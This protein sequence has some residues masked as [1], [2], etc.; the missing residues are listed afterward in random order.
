MITQD[1]NFTNASRSSKLSVSNFPRE[2]RITMDHTLQSLW[3][4]EIFPFEKISHYPS[5]RPLSLLN[6]E[7]LLRRLQHA[8]LVPHRDDTRHSPFF[9]LLASSFPSTLSYTPKA[10][11]KHRRDL[12]P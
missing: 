10:P 12:H 2:P 11:I 5:T 7:M 4:E 6:V 9:L 3:R 8:H 1:Q